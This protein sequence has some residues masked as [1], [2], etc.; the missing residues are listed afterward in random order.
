MLNLGGADVLVSEGSQRCSQRGL[1]EN[2][3]VCT[4]ASPKT[5]SFIRTPAHWDDQVGD[6]LNLKNGYLW[7]GTN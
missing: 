6:H 4:E 2:Q 3:N 5:V 1:Q 7:V